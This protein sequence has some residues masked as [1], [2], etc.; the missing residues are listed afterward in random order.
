M[1]IIEKHIIKHIKDESVGLLKGKVRCILTDVRTG[2]VET[3]DWKPNLITTAGVAAILRNLGNVNTKSDEGA[4]TYGAVGTSTTPPA[5]SDTQLGG[6]LERAVTSYK[7]VSGSELTIQVFFNTSEANGDIKEFGWFGEDASA[8][9]D[10]GT[11]F[12]H[13]SIE[14]TKTSAKTLTIQQILDLAT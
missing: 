12:N 4:I 5:T 1:G 3:T 11:L 7:S 2:K 10:S 14:I 9:A 6:E 13:V 8:A